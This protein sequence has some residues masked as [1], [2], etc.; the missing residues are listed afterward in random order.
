[1]IDSLVKAIETIQKNDTLKP[2]LFAAGAEPLSSYGAAFGTF[3][4]KD[5]DVWREVVEY[6]GVKIK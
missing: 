1:M 5:V 4:R 6:A 3:I 2:Q